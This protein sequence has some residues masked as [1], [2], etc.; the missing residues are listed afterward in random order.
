MAGMLGLESGRI[1]GIEDTG[2]TAIEYPGIDGVKN[3]IP[4]EVIR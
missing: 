2:I 4:Q 3:K 1:A